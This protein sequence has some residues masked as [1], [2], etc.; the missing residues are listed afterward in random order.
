MNAGTSHN[1][2][3]SWPESIMAKPRRQDVCLRSRHTIVN[4]GFQELNHPSIWRKK[5]LR[6][7]V[8]FY[9]AGDDCFKGVIEAYE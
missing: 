2:L 4:E 8:A 6:V 7:R 9:A 1:P 3:Y 5:I